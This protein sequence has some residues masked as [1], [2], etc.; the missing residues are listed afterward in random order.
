MN[1]A[2]KGGRSRG[3]VKSISERMLDGLGAVGPADA[4][5]AQYGWLRADGFDAGVLPFAP[6]GPGRASMLGTLRAF[7][8]SRSPL[9]LVCRAVATRRASEAL[10]LAEGDSRV[11]ASRV[12]VFP[13]KYRALDRLREWMRMP[14]WRPG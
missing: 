6:P 8:E 3:A 1:S 14:W 9:F 13:H 5:R 2:W 7:P 10:G 12:A 11:R 4:C